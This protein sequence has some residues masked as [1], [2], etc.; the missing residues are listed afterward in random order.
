MTRPTLVAAIFAFGTAVAQAD[1]LAL[2]ASGEDL[3]TEGFN[4][5]KLTRDGW[6]LDFTRVIATF[7]RV[8]AW[9]TDPPFEADGPEISGAALVFGGPFTVDL[10]DA[11]DED[12]VALATLPAEAGHYNALS[13]A[14]VPAAQ[15]DFEGFSL[16]FEGTARR[17][18]QEVP[19]VLATRDAVAYACGEYVGDERK[20]FVLADQGADLEITLHLDHLFGRADKP[21]DDAMNLSALGFDA[22]A[23][24]GMQEFSLAGLHVGHVGEGHCHDSAP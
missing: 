8:T 22:F 1:S 15:G 11:D 17:D 19:F 2:F 21:A 18:E 10:V 12:R 6:Q 23:A 4:A 24:G 9:R 20:G 14:L 13:W 7:N 5:P 16:V 3:A